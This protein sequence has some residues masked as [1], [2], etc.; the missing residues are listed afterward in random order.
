VL[1]FTEIEFLLP[2]GAR[3][4]SVLQGVKAC[5]GIKPATYTMR[6]AGK[7]AWA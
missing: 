5:P 4:I 2:A 1:V 7:E 6:T 3:D